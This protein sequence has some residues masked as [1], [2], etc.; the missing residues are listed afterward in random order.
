MSQHSTS[1]KTE[2]L[3]SEESEFHKTIIQKSPEI[4]TVFAMIVMDEEESSV[5][6]KQKMI[7]V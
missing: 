4:W 6:K 2:R 1:N 7:S 5:H 3:Q